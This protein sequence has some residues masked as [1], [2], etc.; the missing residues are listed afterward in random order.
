MNKRTIKIIEIAGPI[1]TFAIILFLLYI[2]VTVTSIELEKERCEQYEEDTGIDT[3]TID[4]TC[5]VM[6]K[7]GTKVQLSN[8]NI[9]TIKEPRMAR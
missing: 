1:L 3:R 2:L 9:A 4:N 7:D 5:Y 8:F 6:L